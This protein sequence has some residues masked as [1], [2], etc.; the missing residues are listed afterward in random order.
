MA[1][2]HHFNSDM[3]LFSAE[4][5]DRPPDTSLIQIEPRGHRKLSSMK[6]STLLRFS[7]TLLLLSSAPVTAQTRERVQFRISGK[8]LFL[9]T[10]NISPFLF[11]KYFFDPAL[12]VAA[13]VCLNNSALCFV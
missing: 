12:L 2:G 4:D 10:L 3:L 7:F 8:G 5:G 11:W 6:L 9:S 13:A 1:S